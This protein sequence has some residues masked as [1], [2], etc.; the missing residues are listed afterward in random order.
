MIVDEPATCGN[1]GIQHEECI[2]CHDEKDETIIPATGKHNY[3]TIID[4]PATCGETGIQH[5]ECTVCHDEKD[6]TTIPA[7]GKHS[8]GAYKTVKAATIYATGKEERK[9]S[10]CGT[11]Q[12]RTVRKL[13][14]KISVAAKSTSVV[15]GSRVTA[16]KVT[17]ANGDKIASWKTSNKAVATVDKYGRIT[18]K[19]AGTAIITVTLKSKKYARIK[20]TVKKKVAAIRVKL[21]R[22]SLTLKRGAS[23]QL[24]A[25]VTPKN[26]TD[27]ITYKTSNKNIVSVTSRGKLVA[28]KRG[29]AT[30]TVTAG[31]KKAS[32]RVVVK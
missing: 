2:V 13:T 7:T 24:R 22:T 5:K 32:C 26:T 29:R 20:V 3:K 28:V 14:A 25:T 4:E 17:Y 9:C 23:F 19:K 27:T 31:K 8:Y 16:P 1:E 12:S 15:V 30:I 18:G 21:N 10:V 6:E 11:K